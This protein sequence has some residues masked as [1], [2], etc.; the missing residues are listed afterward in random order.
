[1]ACARL[2]EYPANGLIVSQ[3]CSVSLAVS[4]DARLP[5][6]NDVLAFAMT[7]LFFLPMA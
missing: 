1:M 2:N 5:E 7:S 6:S 4:P 3:S